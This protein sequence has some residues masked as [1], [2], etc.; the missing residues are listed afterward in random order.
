MYRLTRYNAT[1]TM[2]N[3]TTR[4]S[5]GIFLLLQFQAGAI[6]CPLAGGWASLAEKPRSA[7][8]TVEESRLA[9]GAPAAD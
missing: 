7:G 8:L 9:L 6:R 1:P 3:T 2:I 4:F 5:R